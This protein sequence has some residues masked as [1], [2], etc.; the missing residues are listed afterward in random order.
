[1]TLSLHSL[2]PTLLHHLTL[3]RS[4]HPMRSMLPMMHNTRTRR[5]STPGAKRRSTHERLRGIPSS[6]A[7]RM[8][9]STIVPPS[10]P[11]SAKQVSLLLLLLLMS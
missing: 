11:W 1:M 5:K 10:E 9:R 7:H 6:S 2:D 4:S 3:M 8:M